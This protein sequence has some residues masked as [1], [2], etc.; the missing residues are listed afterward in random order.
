MTVSTKTLRIKDFISPIEF[1]QGDILLDT[2]NA[3]KKS[4]SQTCGGNGT[5]T[6]CRVFVL[7]GLKSCSQRTEIEMERALERGFSENERLACQTQANDDL[8]IEIMNP[9]KI[10]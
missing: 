4:I 6:T 5:C 3:A 8:E 2:L 10:D 7:K 9:E 1:K